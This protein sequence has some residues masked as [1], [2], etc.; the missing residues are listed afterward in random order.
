MKKIVLVIMVLFVLATLGV[1]GAQADNGWYVCSVV[2]CGMGG[3]GAVQLTDTAGAFA[4]RWFLIPSAT[5]NQMLA[6]A[7]TAMAN[8]K[9]VN[10]FVSSSAAY[11]NITAIYLEP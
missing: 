4:N 9:N 6:V 3:S 2:Q 5:T 10:V 1:N 8:N 11:S 7:L